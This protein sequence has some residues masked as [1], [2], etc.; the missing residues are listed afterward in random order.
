[1]KKVILLVL[2]LGCCAISN[3]CF[4][5]NS[6]NTCSAAFLDSK[7]VV[8]TYSKTGK[9]RLPATATGELT[10]QTVDLSPTESKALAKITF[11]I[12]IRDQATQTLHLFSNEDFEQIDVQKV[13]AKCRK[14]DHIVL[15]TLDTRYA[16]P[17]HEI[18]VQ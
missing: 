4:S 11:K 15:L 12:A 10:V 2:I 16:L 13:L 7:I 8:D 17:H 6:F 14:G 3:L 1:M 18:L 5:Q 9:C